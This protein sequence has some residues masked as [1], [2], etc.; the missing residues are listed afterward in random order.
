MEKT[1][2]IVNEGQEAINEGNQL[3][4]LDIKIQSI[5]SMIIFEGGS[6]DEE[7]QDKEVDQQDEG[8]KE[9][10]EETETVPDHPEEK[11]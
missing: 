9:M 4:A 7:D 2:K 5:K 11:P 6:E 3:D 10:Q 8:P 1:S